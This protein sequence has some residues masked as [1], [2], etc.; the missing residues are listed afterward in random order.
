MTP[1]E[2]AD[3]AY[4]AFQTGD[5]QPVKGTLG[6]CFADSTLEFFPKKKFGKKPECCALGAALIGIKVPYQGTFLCTA[7]FALGIT[8]EQF[9]EFARG[10]DGY[11]AKSFYEPAADYFEAGKQL[12]LRMASEA[13]DVQR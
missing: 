3:R 10:F 4:A 5:I 9:Q 1:Q 2:I 12:R 7:E 11:F 6:V 13:H 8:Y